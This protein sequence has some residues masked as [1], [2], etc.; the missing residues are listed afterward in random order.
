LLDIQK[1]YSDVIKRRHSVHF[2]HETL[3]KTSQY[4]WNAYQDFSSK[5]D[6]S[7]LQKY[8][9]MYRPT[10]S[11]SE[12]ENTV[13]QEKD[14]IG[15]TSHPVYNIDKMNSGKV[16]LKCYPLSKY[17]SEY[18][19]KNLVVKGVQKMPKPNPVWL[20]QKN[21][22]DLSLAHLREVAKRL[23]QDIQNM[24]LKWK[25]SQCHQNLRDFSCVGVDERLA[26]LY[27]LQTY[28]SLEQQKKKENVGRRIKILTFSYRSLQICYEVALCDSQL[29]TMMR[30]ERNEYFTQLYADKLAIRL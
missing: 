12:I 4:R 14:L 29:N 13:Y 5:R 9:S 18:V 2:F 26:E 3:R 6:Q 17:E 21:G 10:A 24:E 30:N 8:A 23:R 22:C 7:R 20:F 15:L 19:D 25:K 27:K 1:K 16:P 11:L 28:V